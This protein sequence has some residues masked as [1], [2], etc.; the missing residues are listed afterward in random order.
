MGKFRMLD[1]VELHKNSLAW[2]SLLN[3]G[4]GWLKQTNQNKTNTHKHTKT[5]A[6]VTDIETKGSKDICKNLMEIIKSIINDVIN[7]MEQVR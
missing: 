5:C 7:D 3:L 1:F 4:K 6:I 2:Y